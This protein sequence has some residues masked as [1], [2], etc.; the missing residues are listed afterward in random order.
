LWEN[1]EVPQH[2][3][4]RWTPKLVL[5]ARHKRLFVL[6]LAAAW[7]SADILRISLYHDWSPRW[8]ARFYA[9]SIPAVLFAGIF[10]WW[11]S[12]R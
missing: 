1:A 3:V 5:T 7:V 11:Y 6:L 2:R 4:K 8:W 12:D 10:L 9:E